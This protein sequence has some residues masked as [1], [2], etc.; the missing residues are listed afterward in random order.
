MTNEYFVVEEKLQIRGP[1]ESLRPELDPIRSEYPVNA[2]SGFVMAASAASQNLLLIIPSGKVFLWKYA[3]IAAGTG[4]GTMA[5]YDGALPSAS[6]TI[7]GYLAPAQSAAPAANPLMP[8]VRPMGVYIYSML[9]LSTP[10][11]AVTIKVGGYLFGVS[12]PD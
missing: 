2:G 8:E 3:Y 9:W 11:S 1:D 6:M 10:A 7:Y 4:G 5:F 12:A